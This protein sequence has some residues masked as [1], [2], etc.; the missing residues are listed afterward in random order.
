MAFLAGAAVMT[1]ELTASR[2]L[3]PFFGNT[4]YTWTA[5]IGVILLALSVG[6]YV[7]GALADRYPTVRVLL[8]LVSAAALSVLLAPILTGWV[9]DA[10]APEG[11]EVDIVWGPLVATL[12]LFAV[13]GVL[14]GTVGPFIVKLLSLR[15]HN[16]RVGASTGVVSMLS[17]VD[18]VLGTFVTGFVLIPSLGT[19]AIFLLVGLTLAVAAAVGYAGVLRARSSTAATIVLTVSLALA[20]GAHAAQ[21]APGPNVVLQTDTFYHR[22]SVL[23]RSARD[24]RSATI[25]LTD[26][27]AQGAQAETGDRLV[28]AYTRYYRLERLFCTSM[29]RAAF[30]GG[31]AYSMP[32]SLADDHRAATID[33]VEVDP[34]IEQIGRQFFRLDDYRGRVR[35][36]TGDARMFLAATRERYDL[37]FGDAFRGR[38]T[39]P[40]HLATREFFDLVRRRLTDD[41]VYM[42]NIISALEGDRGQLFRCV[43]TTLEEVFGEVYVFATDPN[44]PRTHAQNLVL[45]APKRQRNWRRADLAARAKDGELA[46][47]A[48]NMVAGDAMDFTDAIMLTDDYCPVE[49]IVA[50]QLRD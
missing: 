37:I 35:P 32:Q 33:V 28:Y 11:R 50:R 6:Y 25:L 22:I 1:V 29:R 44:R 39:A 5:V 38:R 30:L 10:L 2:V 4:L 12:L 42:M 19:R 15:T 40:P 46:V 14:L 18:S 21:R 20:V 24:G 16:R 36:V 27:S 48:G 31:G 47:M 17:T 13:P 8:H 26:G 43:A 7:G 45:V 9:T 34:E 3:A 49:Y 41:G 23:R